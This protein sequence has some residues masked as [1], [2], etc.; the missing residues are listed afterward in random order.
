MRPLSPRLERGVDPIGLK[1]HLQGM[2]WNFA[3]SSIA[4]ADLLTGI[5]GPQ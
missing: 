1:L 3:T 4:T 2:V 5:V